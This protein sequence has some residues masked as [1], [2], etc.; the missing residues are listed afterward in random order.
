MATISSMYDAQAIIAMILGDYAQEYDIDAIARKATNW[1]DGRLIMETG[2]RLWGIVEECANVQSV[3]GSFYDVSMVHVDWSDDW[4]VCGHVGARELDAWF[5]G[6]DDADEFIHGLFISH[7]K[8]RNMRPENIELRIDGYT[9]LECTCDGEAGVCDTFINGAHV[10]IE[11]DEPAGLLR[12]L[13]D[14][15]HY[16]Y[17]DT[18]RLVFSRGMTPWYAWHGRGWDMTEVHN[19][20]PWTEK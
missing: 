17:V 12:S 4:S 1:H 10:L 5:V 8:P 2:D 3:C 20:W 18:A 7:F 13:M 14:F 9:M 6:R 15:G 16:E 19:P 11:Y